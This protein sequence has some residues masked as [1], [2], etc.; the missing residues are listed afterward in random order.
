[1][2][3]SESVSGSDNPWS[4]RVAQYKEDIFSQVYYTLALGVHAY[5]ANQA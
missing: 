5:T 1:M 4:G 2:S 3:D